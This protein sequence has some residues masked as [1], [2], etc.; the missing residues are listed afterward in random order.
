[1]FLQHFPTTCCWNHWFYNISSNKFCWNQWFY[2]ISKNNVFETIGFTSFLPKQLI[3]HLTCPKLMLL[4]P[5]FFITSPSKQ[6]IL[7]LT[8]DIFKS[9]VGKT[10]GFS[11]LI[12]GHIVKP[13]VLGTSCH[14]FWSKI[15]HDDVDDGRQTTNDELKLS[16]EG[17]AAS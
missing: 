5:L 8:V 3:L 12:L 6:L 9:N 14:V 10:N 2:N 15:N 1:M 4:K 16:G 13:M 7:H 17:A 11:S